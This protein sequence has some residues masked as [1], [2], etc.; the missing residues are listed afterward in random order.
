MDLLSLGRKERREITRPYVNR[1]FSAYRYLASQLGRNDLLDGTVGGGCS[2]IDYNNISINI[3]TKSYS[4][5][6]HRHLWLVMMSKVID[7]ISVARIDDKQFTEFSLLL[8]KKILIGGSSIY[9]SDFQNTDLC[10]AIHRAGFK[11]KAHY[12][13]V[14]RELWGDDHR[15]GIYDYFYLNIPK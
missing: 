7:D 1:A 8:T 6:L 13:A 9:Y 12:Y 14:R 11:T 2:A 4:H 10:K 3:S 15:A 5:A